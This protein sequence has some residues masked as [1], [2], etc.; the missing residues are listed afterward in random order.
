VSKHDELVEIYQRRFTLR[1]FPRPEIQR[2]EVEIWVGNG[3]AVRPYTRTRVRGRTVDDARE[4]AWEVLRNHAGLDRYLAL[5]AREVQ[6]ADPGAALRVEEDAQVIR[7]DVQ[8]ARHLRYPLTLARDDALDPDR[9]DEE[10][11]AFIRHH[12]EAY[13]E[14]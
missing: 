6:A 11:I 5:V 2:V 1:F 8:G 7:V 10:L 9:G 14:P 4:R 12:L 13:L 3:S